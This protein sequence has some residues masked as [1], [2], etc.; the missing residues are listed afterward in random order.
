MARPGL[1]SQLASDRASLPLL[2][3]TLGPEVAPL[4]QRKL[5]IVSR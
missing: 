3:N 5:M 4:C 1:L 2:L